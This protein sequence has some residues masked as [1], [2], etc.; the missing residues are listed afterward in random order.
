M[1]RRHLSY[2]FE[3]SDIVRDKLL[4]VG[5]RSF[6][7]LE[8]TSR[9]DGD[10]DE[11]TYMVVSGYR[12][13]ECLAWVGE[14]MWFDRHV[15]AGEYPPWERHAVSRFRIAGGRV[16]EDISCGVSQ[17]HREITEFRVW[18]EFNSAARQL[19]LTGSDI[20]S[21][22]GGEALPYPLSPLLA[23]PADT[24][25]SPFHRTWS[26]IYTLGSCLSLSSNPIALLPGG[27]SG[28]TLSPLTCTHTHTVPRL[29]TLS[30]CSTLT[31]VLVSSL[32]LAH[33]L[34]TYADVC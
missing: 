33:P 19:P 30:L 14:G 5:F 1:P 3:N 6:A 27:G 4:R 28:E 18:R 11:D 20:D 9:M 12:I 17:E 7:D 23:L 24:P 16:G 25:F 15:W 2:L 29:F 32:S 31:D 10:G 21:S 8:F 34:S 13:G 26:S 22:D